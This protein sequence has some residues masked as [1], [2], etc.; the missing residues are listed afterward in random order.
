[1]GRMVGRYELVR[2]LGRGGMAEVFLARRRGPGGV[3]KRLVVKRIRRERARDPRFLKLFVQEAR[4]SMSLAHKNIVPMFDFGRAGD[5]LFLVME[6]VDGVDL[7]AAF[8]K[9]RAAGT[10]VDPVLAAY[11]VME[12]CQALDYAHGSEGTVVHRDVTPRN[13]LLSRAGEVKLVDFGVATS[14]TDLGGAKK[15][16]GTPAYMAPEQACGENVDGRADVFSLGLIL[17]EA[18]AGH[19]AYDAKEPTDLLEQARAAIVPPL[20]DGAPPALV[21]II[22]RATRA[23]L[24]E[25]YDSARAMHIALDEYLVSTR[26]TDSSR[27][28]PAHRVA[29][30]LRELFPVPP[31]ATDPGLDDEPE[32]PDGRVVT[33]LEDGLEEVVATLA[34][35]DETMRSVAETIVDKTIADGDT[36]AESA[37]ADTATVKEQSPRSRW[38]VVA[39][40]AGALAAGGI[41]FAVMTG[42]GG[43][44]SDAVV[45]ATA[46]AGTAVAVVTGPPDAAP[47][48]DAPP[49]SPPDAAPRAV[50]P[51]KQPPKPRGEPGTLVVTSTP[52]AEVTVAGRGESCADTTGSACKLSLPAGT[53]TL[54]L[55]NP[56]ANLGATVTVE[57]VAGETKTVRETLTRPLR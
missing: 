23:D 55:Y 14:E 53:Y 57:V 25:R 9:A 7:G 51:D 30:W 21:E 33:F 36:P 35:G 50:H 45:P 42:G 40:V 10:A 44:G 29:T 13:V 16:R 47:R 37:R 49:P 41:A 18:L 4:L 46:D 38:P 48:P 28:V 20:P 12:A 31:V 6:Y 19:R 2:P 17:W 52:W 43:G 11:V 1:M 34:P 22:H 54:R 56:S 3:E 39:A 8:D 15:V 32:P 5:E 26:P 27:A 24:D